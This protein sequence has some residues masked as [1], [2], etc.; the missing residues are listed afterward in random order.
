VKE[1]VK[2]IL[3]AMP[4]FIHVDGFKSIGSARERMSWK[5]MPNFNEVKEFA[6]KLEKE[7]NKKGY[8][9]MGEEKRSAVV[10]ISN[11]KKSEL[12]IKKV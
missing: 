1:Y 6:E 2:L 12:K 8:K 10:L 4:D 3:K 9:I 5:K 11:K 7:L